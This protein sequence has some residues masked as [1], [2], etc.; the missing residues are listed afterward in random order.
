MQI[1]SIF[2][3]TQHIKQLFDND[4]ILR[5]VYVRGEILN[6]KRHSSGHCYFT[7]K[8]RDATLRSV[9]FRSRAQF[10]KFVPRDGMKVVAAGQVTIFERDG[11]YQLY[12][13]QLIPEGLGE[14][15]LAF[16]QLKEK[17]AAEGLFDEERK[18]E[19]PLFP[20]KIG[21]VTS[22][23]GAA[24]RDIITVARRRHP[25]I[26]L[27]LCPVQVQGPEAPEQI[28]S[29]I[30]ALNNYGQA[31]V[32]IVG[33]GGGSLE[34]LWAFNDEQVVRAIAASALPVVSAV[35]HE[36]DVTL[37]DFAADRRAAT[38]S[39]AAEI[40]V[41]D[42]SE[43][44]RYIVA[45]RTILQNHTFALLKN[46]R[47]QVMQYRNST[48][49]NRPLDILAAKHQLVDMLHERLQQALEQMIATKQHSLQLNAEKLALLNPLA[50]LSRGY[51]ITRLPDGT[52]ITQA[53]QVTVD[54]EIDIIL[55]QGAL[56]AR[57]LD[58]KEATIRG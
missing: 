48:V 2:E 40:A 49:F 47:Q 33:R 38:P 18:Q 30:A 20:R 14:L 25:G 23:T 56:R 57:V 35:G 37:A 27:L 12:V 36:T 43:L 4:C 44:K 45:L 15:S 21:I 51:S 52:I 8:D 50:V 31:D 28:A 55:S 39:Q 17:L 7:L 9:M 1:Y 46:L 54:A 53:D 10:L 13:N 5:S 41:P 26:H 29:A 6:F 11:Q 58:Q 22:P 3:L 42:V 34:E 16:A 32:I 19:L 24:I